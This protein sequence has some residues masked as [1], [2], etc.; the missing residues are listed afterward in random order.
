MTTPINTNEL[1]NLL[2]RPDTD[3]ELIQFLRVH[4]IHDRPKTVAQLIEEDVIEDDGDT[5]VEY[6][7]EQESKVSMSVESERLGL[8]LIFVTGE[9]YALLHDMSSYGSN[10]PGFILEQ[11]V[12]FAKGVQIY[13]QYA[14]ALPGGFEFPI[15]RWDDRYL[16]LGTPVARRLV[17]DTSCDLFLNHKFVVNFGFNDASELAHVHVRL[18]HRFD[19]TMV[20]N[21]PARMANTAPALI[22]GEQEVGSP[23]SS[24]SVQ[25]LFA[26]LGIDENDLY[27][28]TCP[29]EITRLTQP[30]GISLYFD[31]IA[32]SV[33]EGS[34]AFGEQKR[35]VG[36]TFKRRGD[37]SSLGYNGAL[38]FSFEFGDSPDTLVVKA[39]R[40]PDAKHS[41][42]QLLSYYWQ[43]SSGMVVQAV[44]SL[45]D[46]QLYRV[47][48]HAAFVDLDLTGK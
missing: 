26:H 25:K 12:F 33:A 46:W 23:V 6:E 13:Q 35:L 20:A 27:R 40:A 14:G 24:A 34:Q 7:L 37:L 48:L 29:K 32:N 44:C 16:K 3:T 10:L 8:C 9:E 41:S 42:N 31:D 43:L 19:A 17:Y 28:G 21:R 45:I 38:P 47:T 11:V 36:V 2:G 4:K 5:D 30:Q 39:A 15:K 22:L 1:L 18:Q